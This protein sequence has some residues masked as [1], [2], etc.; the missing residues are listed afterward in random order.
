MQLRPHGNMMQKSSN[1]VCLTSLVNHFC[2]PLIL[3]YSYFPVIHAFNTLFIFIFQVF[4][5]NLGIFLQSDSTQFGWFLIGY[6]KNSPI[7]A[8]NHFHSLQS[9]L[10]VSAEPSSPADLRILVRTHAKQ[11][12]H[13][14]SFL[15]CKEQ[16]RKYN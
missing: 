3:F 6:S 12:S 1:A 8:R 7:H 9:W 5:N 16:I 2:P 13:P 14:A 4:R 11:E 10:L 15:C